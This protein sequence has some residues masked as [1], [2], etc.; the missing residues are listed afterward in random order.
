[1][2]LGSAQNEDEREQAVME[3]YARLIERAS[4]AVASAAAAMQDVDPEADGP[5]CP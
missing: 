3:A 5:P 2:T 4:E 1:M